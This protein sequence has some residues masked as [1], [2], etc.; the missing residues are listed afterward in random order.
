MTT[1][2]LTKQFGIHLKKGIKLWCCKEWYIAA[3]N[4][5]GS[6]CAI[7]NILNVYQG[8]YSV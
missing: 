3:Q 8:D 7:E 5:A 4:H 2:S 6:V 1:A